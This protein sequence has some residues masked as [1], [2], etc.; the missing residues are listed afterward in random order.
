MSRAY[1][2]ALLDLLAERGPLRA[3]AIESQLGKPS[4]SNGAIYTLLGRLEH[5]GQVERITQGR[6]VTWTLPKPDAFSALAK[7]WPDPVRPPERGVR[8]VVTLADARHNQAALSC[9]R[10]WGVVSGM[11]NL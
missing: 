5:A 4:N 6:I 1:L 7:A 9:R 11:V 8:H 10:D 2:A 3:G